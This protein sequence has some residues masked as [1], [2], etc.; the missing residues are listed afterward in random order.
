MERVLDPARIEAFAGRAIAP[1]RLPDR[2]QAFS[3]R[4]ARLR[5]LSASERA[6]EGG[7]IGDYLRLM[8]VL[9]DAQQS[10]LSTLTAARPNPETSRLAR[11]HG[12]PP[13]HAAGLKREASWRGVLGELCSSVLES[14]ELPAAVRETCER[15]RGASA[16]PLEA[17]A[18][19]LLGGRVV[20]LDLAA[21]PLIMGA[22][23]VYWLGLA[24]QFATEEIKPLDIHGVCPVCGSLPVASVVRVDKGSCGNSYLH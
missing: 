13:A 10:A 22:L 2:R 18:D 4:G 20:E 23:Q 15:L 17:Q 14:G 11:T 8:A 21:A 7:A 19:A 12:M 24:T 9:A 6:G 3:R 16:A 1:I 5:Q